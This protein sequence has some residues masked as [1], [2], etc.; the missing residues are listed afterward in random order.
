LTPVSGI[1]FAFA[2]L[3]LCSKT[4]AMKK[5]NVY[6]YFCSFKLLKVKSG[7]TGALK[8]PKATGDFL[9]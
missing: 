4:A 6:R 2:I 8:D 3:Q 1:K 9:V 5:L 7:T